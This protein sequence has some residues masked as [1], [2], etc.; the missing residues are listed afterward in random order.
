MFLLYPTKYKWI[1]CL[2]ML[3]KRQ[4]PIDDQ[5]HQCSQY[6]PSGKQP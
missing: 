3:G 6:I 5:F 2:K 4:D 1:H